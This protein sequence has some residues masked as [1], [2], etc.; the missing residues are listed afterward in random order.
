MLCLTI[1]Y[2]FLKGPFYGLLYVKDILGLSYKIF[3]D[4]QYK[5]LYKPNY[6]LVTF[7]KEKSYDGTFSEYC[8]ILSN[9]AC[10][11]TFRN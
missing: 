9:I 3:T 6:L 5:D 7:Y 11:Y 1:S 2:N 10:L 4:K 8:T